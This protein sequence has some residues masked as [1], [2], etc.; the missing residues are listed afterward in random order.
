MK[1]KNSEEFLSKWETLKIG[2]SIKL[3]GQ[4]YIFLKIRPF[5]DTVEI[6]CR[7]DYDGN[8]THYRKEIFCTNWWSFEFEDKING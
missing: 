8:I 7:L 6:I 1:F 5:M 4:D 2:Q 3:Y